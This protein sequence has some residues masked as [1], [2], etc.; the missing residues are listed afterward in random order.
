MLNRNLASEELPVS[1]DWSGH[2]AVRGDQHGDLLHLDDLEVHR[3]QH[4][5]ALQQAVYVGLTNFVL[6]IV[7]VLCMDW[8][9]RRVILASRSGW[10]RCSGV[11]AATASDRPEPGG[12]GAGTM[13]GP[14]RC[15]C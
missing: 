1:G 12:P 15:L 13:E 11:A 2:A 5:P 3:L 14:R 6:T 8:L 9:G 10:G 7:A 4:Q